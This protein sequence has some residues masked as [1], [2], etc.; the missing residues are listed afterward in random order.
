MTLQ[1]LN[2]QFNKAQQKLINQSVAQSD[3]IE[4]WLLD[5]FT[6]IEEVMSALLSGKINYDDPD[7][8]PIVMV[9]A[10]L[11]MDKLALKIIDREKERD[12]GLL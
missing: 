1:E 12:Q 7:V 8:K 6:E 5:H 4:K 9:L 10:R 3:Q 11:T 2:M